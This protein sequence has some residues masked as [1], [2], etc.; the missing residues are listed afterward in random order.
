MTCCTEANA[1]AP[2]IIRRDTRLYWQPQRQGTVGRSV[3]A[4]VGEN[5]GNAV[6]IFGLGFAGYRQSGRSASRVI[7]CSPCCSKSG[8]SP[9]R[10]ACTDGLSRN[11]QHVLFPKPN[12]WRF[13]LV[14]A[15]RSAMSLPL[16]SSVELSVHP[17]RVEG[18]P[19]AIALVPNLGT[20]SANHR[21]ERQG[22]RSRG[23]G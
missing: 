14:L 20:V 11:P 8:V 9:L 15:S 18:S 23:L 7:R 13:P 10:K 4:F 21:A 12:V 2:D 6:S 17:A 16:A 5:P 3:G 19:E 1:A 22:K